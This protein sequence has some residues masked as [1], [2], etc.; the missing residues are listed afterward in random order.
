M[1]AGQSGVYGTPEVDASGHWRAVLE[2]P[3]HASPGEIR[4][5]YRRAVKQVHPDLHPDDAT[6]AAHFRG[7]QE[8]YEA[9]IVRARW[10][11]MTRYTDVGE[12][13]F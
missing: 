3:E 10:N 1:A 9:L 5:A 2:V 12:E 11:S 6:A 8:A 7:L 13:E 4:R